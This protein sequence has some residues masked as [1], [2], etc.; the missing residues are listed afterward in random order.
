MHALVDTYLEF[1]D[2]LD[3]IVRKLLIVITGLMTLTIIL[4]VLFRYILQNPLVWTE[5]L[6]RYLMIWMAFIGASCIIKKWDNIYV[7]FFI[8]MLQH[9][10]RFMAYLA[11]KITV[12][13]VLSYTFYLCL[14]VIPHVA[15]NQTMAAMGI[16]M[17]WVQ[18]AVIVGLLLMVL[19]NIG[20][21]LFDLFKAG[22]FQAGEQP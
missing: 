7:D 19:Q 1:M 17:M 12:L 21:I 16:S 20:I 13:F 11:Q 18:S 4:Q 14:K 2:F 22:K 8:N 9:K 5:E 3:Q 15:G 6:A 10:P